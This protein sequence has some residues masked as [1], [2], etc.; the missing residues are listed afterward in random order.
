MDFYDAV[1]ARF[2]V[3]K[4]SDRQIPDDVLL[5]VLDAGRNAP[6]ACNLQPWH[7]YVVRDASVKASLFPNGRQGWVAAAP[8][9]I[10]ACN[11]PGTA[12]VR[13]YDQKN[14]ADVDLSIAMEHILLAAATEGL[15]TCWV[16][17]FD[18]AHATKVL[19]LP[20]GVVP[21]AITPLGYPEEAHRPHDRK[22]L[23]ET[24]TFIG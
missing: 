13:G 8:V 3:R 21:V 23:E 19:G 2:S 15:G 5:R 9:V 17:S 11:T 20:E 16:G 6:S 22:P 4:Y 10:V 18:P 14:H 7:F 12:W 24:V 1:N